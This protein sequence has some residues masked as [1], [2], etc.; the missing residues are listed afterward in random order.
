MKK[1][2]YSFIVAIACVAATGCGS[3]SSKSADGT[4]VTSNNDIDAFLDAYE[5]AM[6]TYVDVA[7]KAN[8]GDASALAE[9]TEAQA[10]MS[11]AADKLNDSEDEMTESQAKRLA[12][13]ASKASQAS[14]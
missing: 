6:D 2:F 11:A 8:S 10:K 1:L 12:E 3:N 4:E 9:M 5:D 13:I 14:R 7:K